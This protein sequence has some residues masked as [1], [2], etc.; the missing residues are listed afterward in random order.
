MRLLNQMLNLSR[1][2]D[3][4]GKD[5][6]FRFKRGIYS[7][8]M[9]IDSFQGWLFGSFFFRI[10]FCRSNIFNWSKLDVKLTINPLKLFQA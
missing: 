4:L 10:N 8:S 9:V 7:Y 2:F 3:H 5:W 6:E 1:I